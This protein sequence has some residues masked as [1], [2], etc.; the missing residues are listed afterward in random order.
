MHVL[1]VSNS[2]PQLYEGM[3]IFLNKLCN[4][5]TDSSEIIGVNKKNYFL[6]NLSASDNS[7]L[8]P[9]LRNKE[10]YQCE[11]N[12]VQMSVYE[13]QGAETL[14]MYQTKVPANARMLFISLNS[15]TGFVSTMLNDIH[16]FIKNDYKQIETKYIAHYIYTDY[17]E[18]EKSDTYSKRN[19]STL[20]LP[21]DT[22]THLL[23]DVEHFYTDKHIND[24]YEAMGISQT[25]I[26]L[27]YGYPGTG[28]TTSAYVIASKLNLN[29][30]T[31]DFTNKV[32]DFV[33]RKCIKALPQNSLL[34]IEDIDHL[35]SPK[36][37]KDE[38]RHSITFSGL[39]NVL[40]GVS[41]VKKLVCIITCNNIEVLDKTL[42]RRV[43]YS[44]EFK[45]E[46]TDYQLELF[47]EKLPFSL[48]KESFIRFFKSKETTINIIQKWILYHLHNVI[49]KKYEITDKLSEFNEYNR[50]Y[51]NNFKRADL[52][53]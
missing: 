13:E 25:R 53:N 23:N 44:I 28:K 6:D 39:L 52:Y 5:R 15:E 3:L 40:D 30:C 20:Y 51:Q 35:F 19:P 48:N 33:F 41:K 24:F 27:L 16:N 11:Y 29:I 2:S 45:N 26:Y 31:L 1:K 4:L 14:I 49:S 43:D 46:V 34:L 36:K 18:W 17:F 42:L 32:D 12:D 21:K 9:V 10:V 50:W 22:K 38:L 8:L 7:I 47:C 37:D